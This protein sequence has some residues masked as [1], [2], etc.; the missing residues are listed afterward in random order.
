MCGSER[1]TCGLHGAVLCCD[2]GRESFSS[3]A[4]A[5]S[6]RRTKVL[7]RGLPRPPGATRQ[8]LHVACEP[9]VAARAGCRGEDTRVIHWES[10]DISL[11]MID[12]YAKFFLCGNALG[13]GNIF[14]IQ[15]NFVD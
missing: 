8:G 1:S 15:N 12:Y 14:S 5:A 11:F 10:L 9:L 3:I 13:R 4:V 7:Q 6:A 2:L